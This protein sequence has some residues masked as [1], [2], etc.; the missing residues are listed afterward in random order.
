MV[1]QIALLR[2]IE[3]TWCIDCA[4]NDFSIF[5]I[6]EICSSFEKNQQTGHI[7]DF[8]IFKSFKEEEFLS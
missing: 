5:H 8:H 2:T 1:H 6:T 4:V 7:M 3:K